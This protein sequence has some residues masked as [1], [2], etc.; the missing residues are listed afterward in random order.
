MKTIKT[1]LLGSVLATGFAPLAQAGADFVVLCDT[2]GG[3]LPN[4]VASITAT[5]VK[6]LKCKVGIH[7]HDDIGLGVANAI[8]SLDVQRQSLA[9]AQTSLKDTQARIEIG[10]TAPVDA[11]EAEAEVATREESVIVA[12]AQIS[13]W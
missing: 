3:C 11:I 4:E 7:T 10:T 5:A 12:A 6:N 13:V 9:L 8:A 2:N 1:I